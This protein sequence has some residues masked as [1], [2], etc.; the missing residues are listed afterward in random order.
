MTKGNKQLRAKMSQPLAAKG[1]S[2]DASKRRYMTRNTGQVSGGKEAGLTT[3]ILLNSSASIKSKLLPGQKQKRVGNDKPGRF[4]LRVKKEKVGESSGSNQPAHVFS[5][6]T[7]KKSF[8]NLSIDNP[9][10]DLLEMY[11]GK[12]VPLE[13]FKY[14]VVRERDKSVQD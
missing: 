7:T 1:R 10:R 8:N 5:S 11:F 2:V 12:K 3:G 13:M 14:R 9:E 6:G 4:V